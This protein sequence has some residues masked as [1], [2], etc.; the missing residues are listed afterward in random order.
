MSFKTDQIE[1]YIC[2]CIHKY[3]ILNSCNLE[4]AS[5]VA[6]EYYVTISEDGGIIKTFFSKYLFDILYRSYF[7]Y[8]FIC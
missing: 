3:F 1:E 5:S 6:A 4:N 8:Y 7:F 2:I